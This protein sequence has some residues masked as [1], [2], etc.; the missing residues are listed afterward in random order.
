[1]VKIAHDTNDVIQQNVMKQPEHQ[2]NS[3]QIISISIRRRR[4]RVDINPTSI[5]IALFSGNQAARYRSLRLSS[6][7]KQTQGIYLNA[8]LDYKFH[9]LTPNND[10]VSSLLECLIQ[11]KT[12]KEKN[13]FNFT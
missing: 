9:K 10:R 7:V 13:D 6:H 3:D 1:M 4:R 2:G 5:S 11:C 8:L 12:R